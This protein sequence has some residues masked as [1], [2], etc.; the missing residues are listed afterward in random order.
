MH[1]MNSTRSDE[2]DLASARDIG[3]WTIAAFACTAG[4][5]LFVLGIAGWGAYRDL[6]E[7]RAS[8]LQSEVQRLRSHNLRTVALIQDHLNR[9][10][11]MLGLAAVR[12]ADWL[13]THWNRWI[14]VDEV[15]TYAAVVDQSGQ[16]V[17]H[18]DPEL[19]GGKLGGNWYSRAAPEAGDD[20]VETADSVLTGGQ[21]V[22]DIQVPIYHRDRV[23]GDYHC[24]FNY[25]WFEQQLEKRLSHIR[26]NW[27]L[28][29]GV[30]L[31]VAVIAGLSLM[32]ITRRLTLLQNAVGLARVRR[33]AEL[34]QL[35]G[36]IAHE[37][38]NPLNAIR[39]NLHAIERLDD[40]EF[41]QAN[42]ES[43]Q[44]IRETV[45]E[46]GRVEGLVRSLLDY[47]RP[48]RPQYTRLNVGQEV[49]AALQFLRPLMEREH[50]DLRFSPP[51]HPA[52]VLFDK[53][54]LRQIVLN[55]VKNALE[56]AGSEGV[57]GV[58][59]TGH[60]DEVEIR[61]LNNGPPISP[62]DRERIFEPFFT[63][64]ELGT[65][66]GLTLVKRFVEEAGGSIV[67]DSALPSGTSFRI[68]LPRTE[69]ESPVRSPLEPAIPFA[70]SLHH[71]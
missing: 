62:A 64:K 65:G 32:H 14:P 51:D 56:A 43:K 57:V 61:V 24:G 58:E 44:I 52:W 17:M 36:G 21:N 42:D 60:R 41:L 38:R 46:L 53:N 34:G 49:S 16:I 30:I 63:T 39:L 50:V 33:L 66:L 19:E 20:V 10:S 71:E 22:F 2:T 23:V 6:Q 67:C 69:S 48:E 13:R 25:L 37:I 54:R 40:A 27:A 35:A 3:R 5:L 68:R 4:A 7:A 31:V 9:D 12:K 70:A 45:S 8:L 11:E 1:A 15:R 47:A 28:R 18:S 26:W 59:I 55:L 29:L